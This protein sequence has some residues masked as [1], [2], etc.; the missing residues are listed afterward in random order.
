MH[1]DHDFGIISSLVKIDTTVQPLQGGTINVL[2]VVGTGGIKLPAGDTL[3]RIGSTGLIRFN[4]AINGIEYFDG[5]TWDTLRDNGSVTA[6]ITQTAHGFSTMQLLE[7]DPI[8]LKYKAVVDLSTTAGVVTEVI[9]AN[10]F[11][12]TLYG[13][14]SGWPTTFDGYTHFWYKDVTTNV[15]ST[16]SSDTDTP[17]NHTPLLYASMSP[18]VP[19]II[20][21]SNQ[22][23]YG[24]VGCFIPSSPI[25]FRPYLVYGFESPAPA[26]PRLLNTIHSDADPSSPSGLARYITILSSSVYSM[27]SMYMSMSVDLHAISYNSPADM[28]MTVVLA[29]L[30]QP[31]DVVGKPD[32]TPGYLSSTGGISW[33][34]PVAGSKQV[35]GFVNNDQFY[36][37]IPY[38]EQASPGSV[39]I[40]NSAPSVTPGIPYLWVQ[41]GLNTDGKGMTFWIE[42]GAI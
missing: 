1:F 16:A 32:G 9:D 5:T 35:I 33:I 7:Y 22:P 36:Y 10:T 14:I 19:V 18:T 3:A 25:F 12:L 24:S 11:V 30:P 34:A 39:Y 21:V 42:D 2:D 27:P 38:V 17:A 13:L 41:T 37:A 6:T 8:Q 26:T 23:G 28:I 20:P 29:K 40:S 4:S 15:V 31:V